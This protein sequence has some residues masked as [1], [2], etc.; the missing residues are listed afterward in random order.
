MAD[1]G[2]GKQQISRRRFLRRT[3]LGGV[4]LAF[5]GVVLRHVTGYRLEP[6]AAARLRVL[7]PK[8]LLVLAAVCRRIL[9]PDEAGAPSSDELG[10]PYTL[11]AYL[12]GLDRELVSDLRALLHVVEHSPVMWTL[13]PSR[14]TRLDGAAQDAVLDD[15]ATSRLEF[16]RQGFMALKSLAM[17][18]YY[19]D[20]RTFAVL[21][22]TGP[23]LEQNAPRPSPS[24][25]AQ[26]RAK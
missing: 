22:Y 23:L 20:A 6:D 24:P 11:D 16:R 25:S 26:G 8:E 10:V 7:S 4:A 18:G 1:A 3:L 12:V 9:A 17:L 19:G 14:F 13:R 5:G 15:W 2:D 21:G